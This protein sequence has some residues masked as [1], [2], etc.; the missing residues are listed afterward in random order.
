MIHVLMMVQWYRTTD[1]ET[2]WPLMLSRACMDP[3]SDF[4]SISFNGEIIEKKYISTFDLSSK[5]KI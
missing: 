5:D 3:N 4:Q 1:D 2:K